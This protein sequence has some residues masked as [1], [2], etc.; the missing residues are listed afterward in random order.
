M[1]GR[2]LLVVDGVDVNEGTSFNDEAQQKIERGLLSP[3]HSLM[4]GCAS[5][6][7]D[8]VYVRG[9]EQRPMPEANELKPANVDTDTDLRLAALPLRLAMWIGREPS[10]SPTG[11]LFERN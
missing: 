7:I 8:A 2:P 4:K 11:F 10:L 3:T 5:P 1:Q 6:A 9:L